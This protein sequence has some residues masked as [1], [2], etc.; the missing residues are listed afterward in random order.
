M[1]TPQRV[2]QFHKEVE[3]KKVKAAR[4]ALRRQQDSAG[5]SASHVVK[6]TVSTVSDEPEISPAAIEAAP[7]HEVTPDTSPEVS[8]DSVADVELPAEVP[9][10][11]TSTTSTRKRRA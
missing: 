7:E 1:R 6:S 4:D 8:Q 10:E 2:E 9:A 5:L 3:A 11:T